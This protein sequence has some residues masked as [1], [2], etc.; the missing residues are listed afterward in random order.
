MRARAAERPD[1]VERELPLEADEV[2]DEIPGPALRD[3]PREALALV[4]AVALEV[5]ELAA[6]HGPAQRLRQDRVAAI[7]HGHLRA[8]EPQQPLDEVPADELRAADDEGAASEGVA[9]REQC[10]QGE[11]T[12]RLSRAAH[13]SVL[14]HLWPSRIDCV[15]QL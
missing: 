3:E 1:G 6:C 9:A 11:R 8:V 12:H 4:H 2:D 7:E 13:H 5:R 10:E 14:P 15:V